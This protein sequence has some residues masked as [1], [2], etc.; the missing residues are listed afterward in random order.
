MGG[1]HSSD[2]E[3][4]PGY[5]ATHWRKLD[6]NHAD[7]PKNSDWEKAITIFETRIRGRFIA[8]VEALIKAEEGQQR[9]MFG[10]ASLAIDCLLIETLQGF[11]EGKT[12][13]SGQSEKLFIRFLRSWQ[14]FERCLPPSS[15]ADLLAKEFYRDCRCALHHS[16]ATGSIFRVGVSGNMLQFS[17]KEIVINRLAFH[18]ELNREFDG[19][20]EALRKPEEDVLRINLKTKMDFICKSHA[21]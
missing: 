16:G 2:V 19:Y 1:S 12:N 8:P 21:P 11:R 9:K 4:A 14:S 6:L 17:G 20:L 3:I 15:D 13:H 10:F 5:R 18:R 7:Q